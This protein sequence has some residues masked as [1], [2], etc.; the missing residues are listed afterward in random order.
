MT[1]RADIVAEAR[2]WVGVPFVHQG[3]SRAGTDC[4]GL[5]GAVAVACGVV[6][7]SWW[8]EQFDVEHGGY[9]RTPSHG[10]LERICERFLQ[11]ID[12]ATMQPGD[13]VLMSFKTEPQHLAILGNYVHGGLSVIHALS[14]AGHV[15]EHR[16]SAEWRRLV[17]GAYSMPG[18]H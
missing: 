17:V 5:V 16:L 7:P 11:P 2:S 4:G 13:V 15:A 9:A 14:R 1:T 6:S 18:V 10:T 8:A 12:E 3:R